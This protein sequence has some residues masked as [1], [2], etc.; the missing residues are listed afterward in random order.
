MAKSK[1][2]RVAAKLTGDKQTTVW[3]KSKHLPLI[4]EL[5]VSNHEFTQ[6]VF[7][8][9]MDLLG[10]ALV[11]INLKTGITTVKDPSGEPYDDAAKQRTA[12]ILGGELAQRILAIKGREEK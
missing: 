1:G 4:K 7:D 2:I 12:N 10:F 3:I 9:A 8:S 11:N 6:A 5:G